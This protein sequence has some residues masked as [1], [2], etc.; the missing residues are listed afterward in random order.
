MIIHLLMYYESC[1]NMPLVEL[2]NGDKIYL[3]CFESSKIGEFITFV[4]ETLKVDRT[5]EKIH[6]T[7]GGAYKY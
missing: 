5:L 2:S 3:K 4:K 7:G 1:I 6:A